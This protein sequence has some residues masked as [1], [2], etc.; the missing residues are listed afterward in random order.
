MR[1]FP[2]NKGVGVDGF[3][4]IPIIIKECMLTHARPIAT[5]F[6]K[7]L[8]SGILPDSLKSLT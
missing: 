3:P 1:L 5:M 7:S 8:A 6:N 4:P 2:M